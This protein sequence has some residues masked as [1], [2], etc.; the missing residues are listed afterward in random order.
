[1][2][3]LYIHFSIRLHGVVLNYIIT[4]SIT[5]H[6]TGLHQLSVA[7]AYLNILAKALCEFHVQQRATGPIRGKMKF[8][9]KLLM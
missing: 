6:F 5:L 8:A 4:Y 9:R 7:R 2:A 1:M 3:E